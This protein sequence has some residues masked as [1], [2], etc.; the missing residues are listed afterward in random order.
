MKMI[1]LEAYID[2]LKDATYEELLENCDELLSFV[3]DFEKQRIPDDK[4]AIDL[5]IEVTYQVYL[6]YFSAL[7]KRI[8]EVYNHDSCGAGKNNKGRYIRSPTHKMAVFKFKNSFRTHPL[9]PRTVR[10]NRQSWIL[11]AYR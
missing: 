10:L 11:K 4:R 1:S 7:C 2:G 9:P 5:A 6:Q 8:T 3:V